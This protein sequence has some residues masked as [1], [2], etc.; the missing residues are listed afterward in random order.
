MFLLDSAGVI[1]LATVLGVPLLGAITTLV[2][3]FVKDKKERIAKEEL[4]ME[5]FYLNT[6]MNLVQCTETDFLLMTGVQKKAY[7]MTRLENEII[8]AGIKVD[9]LRMSEAVEK[10]VALMNTYKTTGKTPDELK[11]IELMKLANEKKAEVAEAV[12]KSEAI[13]NTAMSATKDTLA[14]AEA[15]LKTKD[16]A[17][18]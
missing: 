5:S 12:A 16:I 1:T 13:A 2:L 15:Y 4:R 3:T 6:A 18:K 7:V 8:A 10:S 11:A 9:K 17:K 14:A